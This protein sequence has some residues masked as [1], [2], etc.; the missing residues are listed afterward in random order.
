MLAE[1]RKG[2]AVL[3]CGW[4]CGALFEHDLGGR[5]GNVELSHPNVGVPSPLNPGSRAPVSKQPAPELALSACEVGR[6]VVGTEVVGTE[7]VGVGVVGVGTVGVKVVV[8]EMFG[9]EGV[10]GRGCTELA[11]S[12]IVNGLPITGH[13]RV[14]SPHYLMR[15]GSG[16]K[17]LAFF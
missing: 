10:D 9:A 7:V 3:E 4:H 2:G 16:T 12:G 15:V 5:P 17:S 14:V 11:V 6:E 1:G 8:A 13:R